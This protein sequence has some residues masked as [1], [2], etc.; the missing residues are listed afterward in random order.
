MPKT[1]QVS[2]SL[3]DQMCLTQKGANADAKT[4]NKLKNNFHWIPKGHK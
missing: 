1:V 4:E 2:A 3:A